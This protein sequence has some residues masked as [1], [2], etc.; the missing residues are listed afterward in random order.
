MP[1]FILYFAFFHSF[2]APL[3]LPVVLI[4]VSLTASVF[5]SSTPSSFPSSSLSFC[6]FSSRSSSCSSYH[7]PSLPYLSSSFSPISYCAS[8]LSW[9]F[10]SLVLVLIIISLSLSLILSFFHM[11]SQFGLTSESHPSGVLLS[12][13]REMYVLLTLYLKLCLYFTL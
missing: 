13:F 8:S 10:P 5:F 2:T 12:P 9:S 6:N 3:F 1:E 11:F 4:H 7:S